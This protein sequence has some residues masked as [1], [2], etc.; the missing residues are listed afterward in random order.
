[1]PRSPTSGNTPELP[2]PSAPRFE[3]PSSKLL[4]DSITVPILV[5]ARLCG[6][7]ER[8]GGLPHEHGT[9]QVIARPHSAEAALQFAID[10]QLE[11]NST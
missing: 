8:F 2:A 5:A 11:P 1:M 9:S 7:F 3:L 10:R 4:S 6:V